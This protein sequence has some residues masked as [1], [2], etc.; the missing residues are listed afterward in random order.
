MPIF[1]TYTSPTSVIKE[2]DSPSLCI[3]NID[4]NNSIYSQNTCL[5]W[6]MI[7]LFFFVFLDDMKGL[8]VGDSGLEL[9]FSYYV[10]VPR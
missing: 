10:E 5:F 7:L 8:L 1:Y 3:R 2:K 9:D 4:N 6:H